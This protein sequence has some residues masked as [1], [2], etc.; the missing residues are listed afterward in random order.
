MKQKIGI[1]KFELEV[2]TEITES[3]DRLYEIEKLNE[4]KFN[5]IFNDLEKAEKLDEIIKDQLVYKGFD[6][7]YNPNRFGLACENLIDKFY[8]I[9]K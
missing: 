1:S 8:E 9:L 7:N 2:I 5:I 4:T 6:I 3:A